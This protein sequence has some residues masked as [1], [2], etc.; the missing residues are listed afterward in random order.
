MDTDQRGHDERSAADAAGK[1][2]APGSATSEN[3]PPNSG[4]GRRSGRRRNG[5]NASRAN[6]SV[7]EGDD[8]AA[9]VAAPGGVVAEAEQMCRGALQRLQL[10][11]RW[12]PQGLAALDRA[13][14]NIVQVQQLSFVED[15][16][17]R[18][19]CRAS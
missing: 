3:R 11:A 17:P 6:G 10:K 7:S 5:S 12:S 18:F 1:P 14:A 9:A 19:Q 8:D 13:F 16:S 2:A 4:R 15:A